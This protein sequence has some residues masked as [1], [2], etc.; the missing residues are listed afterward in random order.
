[1]MNDQEKHKLVTE[2]IQREYIGLFQMSEVSSFFCRNLNSTRLIVKS[3][4]GNDV[5]DSNCD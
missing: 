1:M 3:Q 5:N 4:F 2:S